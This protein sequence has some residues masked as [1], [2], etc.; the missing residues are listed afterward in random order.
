MREHYRGSSPIPPEETHR[1]MQ[2]VRFGPL[3][4]FNQLRA[5]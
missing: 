2:E 1:L 5:S 3:A 4:R